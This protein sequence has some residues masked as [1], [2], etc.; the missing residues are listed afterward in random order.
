MDENRPGVL[1]KFRTEPYFYHGDR[2]HGGLRG[3]LTRNI[4]PQHHHTDSNHTH[5]NPHSTSTTPRKQQTRHYSIEVP[6]VLNPIS[7]S[8]KTN[9]TTRA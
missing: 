7:S 2:Q 8:K 1:R 6:P 9:G 5:S 3:S 4:T